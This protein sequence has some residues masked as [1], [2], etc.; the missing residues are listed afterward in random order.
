LLTNLAVAAFLVVAE[1]EALEDLLL[2][3]QEAEVAFPPAQ[4]PAPA[5]VLL[6]FV[7]LASP[8]QPAFDLVQAA[9]S[10]GDTLMNLPLLLQYSTSVKVALP[11]SAETDFFI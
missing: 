4:Q 11:D 10:L 6:A 7:A 1:E 9:F 8:L 2:S 5:L 3:Q